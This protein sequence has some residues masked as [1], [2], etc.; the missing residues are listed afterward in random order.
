MWTDF[1]FDSACGLCEEVGLDIQPDDVCKTCQHPAE[2]HHASY[3]PGGF[4]LYE[5]CEAWDGECEYECQMFVPYREED[6]I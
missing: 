6:W 3:F 4:Y 5:E 1:S 2:D